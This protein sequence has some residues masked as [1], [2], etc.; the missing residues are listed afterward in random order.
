[1]KFYTGIGSRETPQE[2]LE[3]MKSI[4]TR[5]R[6]LGYILRSGGADGADK[7]FES[8]AKKLKEIYLPWKGFNNNDSNLYNIDNNALE[9]A[10]HLHKGWKYLKPGAKK[11]MARNCYQVLGEDLETPSDFVICWTPDGCETH[12]DRKQKTG[13]TGQAI[14]LADL[15][16]IRVYNLYNVKSIRELE[17]LLSKLE[18]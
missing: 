3:Y 16:E 17:K 15:A 6:L 9:L 12:K 8:N 18:G 4:S 7:A 10:A 5:L 2:I 1:M 13:G 14:S 11:L